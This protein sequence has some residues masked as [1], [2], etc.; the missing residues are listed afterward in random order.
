M[1]QSENP[2]PKMQLPEAWAERMVCPVCS[3]RPLGVFHPS[4]QADRFAC[5]SCETS[6]ELEEGGKRVRFVTL[7]KDVTPWMRGQWV[8]LEE[9]LAAFEIFKK[10]QATVNIQDSSA[11]Q[12]SI[13]TVT[14]KSF[15][16]LSTNDPQDGK[17]LEV[18]V[19][20]T[21]AAD[22]TDEAEEPFDVSK[23]V[24]A[25]RAAR[26]KP[27]TAP[28][29]EEDLTALNNS[30]DKQYAE[31]HNAEQEFW[32]NLEVER[33]NQA[34]DHPNGSD[35]AGTLSNVERQSY[36]EAGGITPVEKA[37]EIPWQPEVSAQPEIPSTP[38]WPEEHPIGQA[39]P[40][41]YPSLDNPPPIR[42][43]ED[44]PPSLIKPV[45]APRQPVS[46]E[47]GED[48]GDLRSHITVASLAP[49]VAE[50]MD[51]ATERAIELHK[52]GNT[53]QEIRAIL[54]RSSGLT[55]E[56]VAQVLKNL[57]KPEEKK[58]G[59]RLLLIYSI[60]AIIL[61][62]LLA[63]WFFNNYSSFINPAV[64]SQATQGSF[65]IAGKLVD[66]TSLPAPLQT[67]IPNGIQVLNEEPSVEASTEAEIPAVSCPTTK[68]GAAGVF[69]GP[70]NDWSRDTNTNGWILIT[71]TQG[72]EVRIPA[73]MTGGYLVFEKGPEMR[74][75][76]GPAIVRNIYMISVSC[77]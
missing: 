7:P 55:P 27:K 37:E 60:I 73:N 21:D 42:P 9:A 8:I 65:S 53:D 10:G 63:W 5:S 72:V 39:M 13:S 54:E 17:T 45:P 66:A 19:D 68:A 33:V 76:N 51:S 71:K 50:R 22:S 34:V 11:H 70:A 38:V 49:S 52:L 35:F 6:F 23:L 77:E 58:R 74:G 2:N 4:G 43:L 62:T 36:A 18:K 16:H 25:D 31:R 1:A 57:E 14:D 24:R 67:L 56:Q 3:S 26:P 32:Q 61:F 41:E 64:Q 29:Y 30:A 44:T 47:P 75:I 40:V 15:E 46:T 20:S 59:S 28:F 69:G 48:L 12:P